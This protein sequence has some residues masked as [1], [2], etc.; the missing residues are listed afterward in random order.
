MYTFDISWTRTA[1]ESVTIPSDLLGD[2][3]AQLIGVSCPSKVSSLVPLRM[4]K[5]AFRSSRDYA[6]GFVTFYCDWS[7]QLDLQFLDGFHSLTILELG[8]ATDIQA[9]GRLPTLPALTKLHVMDSTGLVEFPDL[10]PASLQALFLNG[11]QMDDA[12]AARMLNSVI[13]TPTTRL[14]TLRLNSNRLTKIPIEQIASFPEIQNLYIDDNYFPVLPAGS[15]N[16]PFPVNVLSL[17]SCSIET[18]EPGAF[19]GNSKRHTQSAVD[20]NNSYDLPGDFT[21]AA[22]NLSKNNLSRFE[23]AVFLRILEQMNLPLADGY[24]DLQSSKYSV[25]VYIDLS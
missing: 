14:F 8:L 15:F 9:I 12:L 13:S 10:S 5:D 20:T 17:S 16:L 22:V 7:Q 6:I 2:S 18:I 24:V 25:V 19:V 4:D 21:M 3:R 23:S 11:N 1:L